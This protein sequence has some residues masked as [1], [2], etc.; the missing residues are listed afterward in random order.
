MKLIG[1]IKQY[2]DIEEALSLDIVIYGKLIGDVDQRA[3]LEYLKKGHLLMAWMGYFVD[4]RT[5]E[6]IAPD[7]Y[8][9]DGLWVW[10]TYF[11]YYLEKYPD[12]YIDKEFLYYL[13]D[14]NFVFEVD[15]FF[16]RNKKSFEEE[17]SNRL[18]GKL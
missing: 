8:Y 2:N 7:A 9:T 5:R 6:L 15:D 14:K 16:E 18:S 17:L 1:F 11:P 3:I 4:I 13:R 12:M 10:P